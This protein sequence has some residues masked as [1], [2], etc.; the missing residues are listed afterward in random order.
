MSSAEI[1]TQIS[2]ASAW[3]K[4]SVWLTELLTLNPAEPGY[5]LSL[6]TV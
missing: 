6:Q 4:G 1:F 3:E 5:I 2:W